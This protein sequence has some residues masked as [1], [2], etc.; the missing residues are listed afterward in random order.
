MGTP[1]SLAKVY[2]VVACPQGLQFKELQARLKSFLEIVNKYNWVKW[3][4]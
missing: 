2:V 1:E 4:T 3:V